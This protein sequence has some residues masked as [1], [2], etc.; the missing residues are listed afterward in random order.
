ME[1]KSDE[2][3][4]HESGV[5]L[6]NTYVFCYGSNHPEQ[7]SRRLGAKI[8]DLVSR[9]ISCTLPGFKRVYTGAARTWAGGS[10]ANI[11][12]H[13]ESEVLGYAVRMTANEIKQLDVYEGY[14]HWYTRI[15]VQLKPQGASKEK[16]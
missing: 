10:V 13:P 6:E 12:S 1:G 11:V 8:D 9:S 4:S 15:P 14:P 3:R 2:S 7:L 16:L 5:A